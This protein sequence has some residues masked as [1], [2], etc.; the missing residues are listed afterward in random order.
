MP[1]DMKL[2]KKEEPE[3]VIGPLHSSHP[4]STNLEG[5]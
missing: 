5:K 1:P 4:L 3:N 2:E